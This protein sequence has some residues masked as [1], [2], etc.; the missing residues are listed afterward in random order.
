MKGLVIGSTVHERWLVRQ[1]AE[2]EISVLLLRA[3]LLACLLWRGDAVIVSL[4]ECGM[5]RGIVLWY[6]FLLR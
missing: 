4:L 5:S 2:V 1:I 6:E 3:F